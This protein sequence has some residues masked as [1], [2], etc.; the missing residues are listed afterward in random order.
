LPQDARS[1]LEQALSQADALMY[2]HKRS[3]VR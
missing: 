1:A 3:A 2:T